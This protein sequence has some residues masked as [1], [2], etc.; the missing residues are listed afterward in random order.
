M[1]TMIKQNFKAYVPSLNLFLCSIRG[2]NWK[3]GQIS[4]LPANFARCLLLKLDSKAIFKGLNIFKSKI[5]LD[6]NKYCRRVLQ[7]VL[8]F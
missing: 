2:S 3:I 7:E 5:K 1:N 6:S 8:T 4:F